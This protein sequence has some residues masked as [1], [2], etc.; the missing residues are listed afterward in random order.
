M[1]DDSNQINKIIDTI[2][3]LISLGLIAYLCISIL[4]PFTIPVFWSIIFAVALD[5]LYRKINKIT[6][7]KRKISS[8]M[9]VLSSLIIMSLPIY[10]FLESAIKGITDIGSMYASGKFLIKSP[11][12]SIKSIPMIGNWLYESWELA[13]KNLPS[14]LGQY[15]EYLKQ[16]GLFLLDSIFGTG[17][18]ILNLTASILIAG[19]LLYTKGTNKIVYKIFEKIAGDFGVEFAS[20]TEQ[21]IRNVVKGILGVAVIQ[22]SLAGFGF[23]MVDLPYAGLW[24]LI[25]MILTIVQIGPGFVILP[26][27]IWLFITK[28][29]GHASIWSIYL[30]VVMLLDN[31]LKPILLGK[32]ASV[33]TIVIF[34]G[35][36]GGFIFVGFL[37]LFL[38]AIILSITYKLLIFWLELETLK[39]P[40]NQNEK[41]R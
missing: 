9:V 25:C 10:L 32:G 2:I 18:T 1:N 39:I 24:V 30:V 20:I 27:I 7:N 19:F 33:P 31:I 16:F 22:A 12:E 34:L 14:L 6:G 36:I 3:R 15:Q 13:S 26:V 29:L 21:T 5:P 40:K 41:P 23:L 38:G 28:D 4:K 35:A 37:G 8:I 17:L 11:N